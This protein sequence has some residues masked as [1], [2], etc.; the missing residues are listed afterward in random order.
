QGA[1]SIA[2]SM[3]SPAVPAPVHS[4]RSAPSARFP[5]MGGPSGAFA[6]GFGGAVPSPAPEAAP[7]PPAETTETATQVVFHMSRPVDVADGQ[8]ALLPVIDREVPA[9]RIALYQP[10]VDARHPLAS[11]EL[12]NDGDTG[13]PPGVV[14]TY[15]QASGGDVTYDGDARLA[16]LPAGEK[17]V[18]SFGVD[19]KV[20]IDRSQHQARIFG[21]ATIAGGVLRIARKQQLVTDY[22]IAGAAH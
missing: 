16:T 5:G 4:E 1:V 9:Q 20:T 8:E 21:S 2:E 12:T 11:V 17:R 3:P 22:T 14:T 10:D 15:E 7:T 19:P 6:P 18:V 13:L